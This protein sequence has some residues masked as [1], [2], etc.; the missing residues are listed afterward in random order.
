MQEQEKQER[1]FVHKN[2]VTYFSKRTERRIL[3]VLT[4]FMLVWG[5]FECSR[6]L[7]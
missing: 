7:F 2:G 4:M 5:I 6:D 3:F 1:G